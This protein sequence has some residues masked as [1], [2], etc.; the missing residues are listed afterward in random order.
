MKK[1][2]IVL[3]VYNGE[4]N[5]AK[6][7][8]SVLKQSYTNWELIIV[9]DCSTDSTNNIIK[10]YEERDKRIKVLRN[11][12]NKKLPSSLNIGFKEA[13]GEY[14]TWT[15]DDNI[16]KE[17]ALEVMVL[18]LENNVE[19][20]MVYC[21]T[22]LIDKDDNIIKENELP[23]PERLV[24]SNTVGAC[25]MYRSRIAEIIGEYD[26]TLFLA[27]DY[28]YWLRIYEKSKIKHIHESHYF[29]RC[30]DKSL[31][32]TR[33]NDIRKQTVKVW[34]KHFSFIVSQL[35]EKKNRYLFFDEFLQYEERKL[36]K[37][38]FKKIRK[39]NRGYVIHYYLNKIGIS[40]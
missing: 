14:Y 4:D 18:F 15:S 3:P 20:G 7:I 13:T 36:K 40:F 25:F 32:S 29:Y 17:D 2:S 8:E 12:K 31:S 26:V 11:H 34:K 37:D 5:I 19:Y 33:L 28:E 1:V 21:D 23:E 24:Y 35:Q 9:D 6:S 22:I 30:H 10:M 39:I 16:Y 27:E 38:T